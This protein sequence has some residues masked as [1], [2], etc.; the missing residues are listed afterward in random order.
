MMI[1]S[2]PNDLIPGHLLARGIVTQMIVIS[3][4]R[5]A[6][7]AKGHQSV[8]LTETSGEDLITISCVM[9]YTAEVQNSIFYNLCTL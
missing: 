2:I 4:I 3:P 8:Y 9:P 1:D 7:L 5:V 6:A